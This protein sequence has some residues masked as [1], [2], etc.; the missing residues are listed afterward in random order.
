MAKDFIPSRAA[1]ESEKM[2]TVEDG[3]EIRIASQIANNSARV[4]D[5]QWIVDPEIDTS[6]SSTTTPA[7]RMVAPSWVVML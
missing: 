3:G 4:E 6:G 1:C 5:G 7:P 2:E